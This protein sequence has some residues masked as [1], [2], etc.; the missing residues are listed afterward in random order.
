MYLNMYSLYLFISIFTCIIII[1][2]YIYLSL[3]RNCVLSCF[4]HVQLF[5]TYGL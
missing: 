4:G 2:I 1:A 3:S 5:V